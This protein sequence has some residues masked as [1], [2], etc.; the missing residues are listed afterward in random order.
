[1]VASLDAYECGLVTCA[2][3]LAF[4][5]LF[6]LW[7]RCGVRWHR[8]FTAALCTLRQDGRSTELAEFSMGEKADFCS[9]VNSMV[10]CFVILPIITVES[11]NKTYGHNMEPTDDA[12]SMVPLQVSLCIS[13]GYFF[14]DLAMILVFKMPLWGV[15]AA[16]H[17]FALIPIGTNLYSNNCRFGSTLL[18]ALFLLVEVTTI[19]LNMQTFAEQYGFASESRLYTVCFYATFLLWI[20]S[21]IFVPVAMDTLMITRIA[22]AHPFAEIA[23]FIPG[24][25]SAFLITIFCLAVFAGL[26]VPAL[27][28]RWRPPRKSDEPPASP[29]GVPFIDQTD[30]GGFTPAEEL[31]THVP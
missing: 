1:M 22:E 3:A 10:H 18:I 23:C 28:G 2:T 16:H 14:T 26:L 21:R 9:R 7:W 19:P 24:M 6:A 15:F 30:D 17:V 12:A 31:L 29:T 8:R 11:V 27:V 5:V 20:P 4:A 13:A 25:I